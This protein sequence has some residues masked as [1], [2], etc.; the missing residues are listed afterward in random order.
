[1][2]GDGYKERIMIDEIIKSISE[3]YHKDVE[4]IT[5]VQ[6]EDALLGAIK[7]GDFLSH[8]Q[9]VHIEIDK[10]GRFSKEERR[11]M[12]YIPYREKCEMQ[13]EICRLRGLVAELHQQLHNKN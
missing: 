8:I 6:F 4:E 2:F 12:T 11:A 5:I 3:K 7:S 13:E 1:M 9:N 10:S